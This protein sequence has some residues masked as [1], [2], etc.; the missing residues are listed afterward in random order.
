MSKMNLSSQNY[1]PSNIWRTVCLTLVVALNLSSEYKGKE[2]TMLFS[3][4]W[5]NNFC[6]VFLELVCDIL[7]FLPLGPALPIHLLWS[8]C[9]WNLAVYTKARQARD[10]PDRDVK[11]ECLYRVPEKV[12][13][14][15]L[16]PTPHWRLAQCKYI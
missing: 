15:N 4:R 10:E 3:I 2:N 5:C 11:P 1:N 12:R 9:R 8:I 6:L 7:G 16:W 14:H 13:Q